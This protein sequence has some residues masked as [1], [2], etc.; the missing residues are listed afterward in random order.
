MTQRRWW[1]LTEAELARLNPPPDIFTFD[2][3]G[4]LWQL[5]C[6]Y[7]QWQPVGLIPSPR[8]RFGWFLYH[9]VHGLVMRYPWWKVIGFALANTRP[10]NIC[11][12][13]DGEDR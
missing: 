2:E 5:L 12:E 7:P 6:D 11:V 1:M 3:H 10:Q 9:L 13:S 8:G 4:N